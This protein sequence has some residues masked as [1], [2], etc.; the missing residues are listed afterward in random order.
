MKASTSDPAKHHPSWTIRGCPPA[1]TLAALA[2]APDGTVFLGANIGIL[3]SVAG[4]V[5]QDS[6]SV[7]F[8]A[9]EK[10]PH[11]PVGVLCLALS[12]GFMADHTLVAGAHAGIF[13]STDRGDTWHKA[14]LPMS[15]AMILS[16]DFSPNYVEDGV[17]LA[18]TLEDGIFYSD[19]GGRSWINKSFGLYDPTVLGLALSPGY[20]RDESIF[21]ATNSGV[22]YSYNGARAWKLSGF[23]EAAAPVLSL[24]LS[25]DFT[26][27]H[28]LFAGTEQQGLF[29]STD[30]GKTWQA[31]PLSAVCINALQVLPGRLAAG[32]QL[33][34][35]TEA[36]VFHSPDQGA[37]W[38]RL[39]NLPDV[40]VL[41]IQDQLALASAVDRGLWLADDFFAEPSVAWK[42][43]TGLATRALLGLAL[44]PHFESDGC[45]FVYGPQEGIWVTQDGGVNW[46]SL[47]DSLPSLDIQALALSPRFAMD[48]TLA[49]ATKDG[50]FLSQDAGQNW[51]FLTPEAA[52]RAAFSPDGK[53]LAASFPGQGVRFSQDAG[54]TWQNLPGAWEQGGR[55][56]ALALGNAGQIFIA[57]LEGIGETVT[58]WQGRPGKFNR[59]LS[60]AVG[61]LHPAEPVVSFY[62]PLEPAPDRPWFASLGSQ[63]WKLSLRRAGSGL[64]STLLTGSEWQENIVALT[65]HQSSGALTLFACTGPRLYKSVDAQAWS[66]VHD[67]GHERAVALALSPAYPDNH[68]AYVLLLGG[69]FVQGTV[70]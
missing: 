32:S 69:T 34:A 41:A 14:L 63:V 67:F 65:G 31:L 27:D 4:K 7:S 38:R 42:S 20:G 12:P 21:I 51:Q 57:H 22:Y 45:A 52:E 16:V 35:A 33:L 28:T 40:L 6:G 46:S 15:S 59:V 50:L 68:I 2:I 56:L 30:Q 48:Q 10:L 1:G 44:S 17:M 37:T 26:R 66:L 24:A 64:Q 9:W 3:R 13:Y 53:V 62:I 60:Q 8:P 70:R 18:G 43:V 39:V 55:V 23:P 29:R 47:F 11:S 25:P 54:Q 58:I 36:G 49:I 19:D 61:A 5:D